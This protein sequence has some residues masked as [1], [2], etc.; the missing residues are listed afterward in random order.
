MTPLGHALHQERAHQLRKCGQCGFAPAEGDDNALPRIVTISA[1][2]A[3]WKVH[4]V[5]NICGGAYEGRTLDDAI[6]K[7]QEGWAPPIG[8][9]LPQDF[10]HLPQQGATA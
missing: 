7:W 5:C 6:A 10:S 9:N 8:Y 1:M 3:N 4:L 2:G